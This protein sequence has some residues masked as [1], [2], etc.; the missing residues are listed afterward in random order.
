[1]FSQI[2]WRGPLHATGVGK[3]LLASSESRLISRVCDHELERFTPNTIVE[4]ERLLAELALVRKQG[5]A[6]DAEELIE[7]LTCV[8][9]P[10]ISAEQIRGAISVAGPTARLGNPKRLAEILKAAAQTLPVPL[11]R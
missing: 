6:I 3:V 4:K 7:G 1:M 11:S 9:V 5:Y 2:G 10:V 8:A